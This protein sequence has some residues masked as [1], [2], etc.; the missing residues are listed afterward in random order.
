[1]Q[2][3]VLTLAMAASASAYYLPTNSSSAIS[4][5]SSSWPES[6]LTTKLTTVTVDNVVSVYTTVCPITEAEASATPAATP[7][8]TAP[9]TTA[10]APAPSSVAAVLASSD[11]DVTYTTQ[12]FVTTTAGPANEASATDVNSQPTTVWPESSAAPVVSS[13]GPPYPLNSTVIIYKTAPY[14]NG[15]VPT[16]GTAP[17]VPATAAPGSVYLSSAAPAPAP[18]AT[19]AA[20]AAAAPAASSAAPAAPAP[21]ASSA[22]P[23]APAPTANAAAPAPESSAAP[24]APATTLSSVSASPSAASPAIV[25]YEA[26]AN[27]LG[28][29][30]YALALIPLAYLI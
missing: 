24:A 4:V 27:I 19:A 5:A 17:A 13:A 8:A 29:S 20:P 2:F 10:A 23:A 3:A 16:N 1:M 12:I 15:S 22:A 25:T 14:T 6:E 30:V 28:Q 18:A 11:E 21:A 7:A 9:V 26:G